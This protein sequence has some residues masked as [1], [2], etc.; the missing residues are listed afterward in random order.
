MN[1]RW[2]L[3]AC[4]ALAVC[5]NSAAAQKPGHVELSLVPRYSW[6][7]ADRDFDDAIGIGGGLAVYLSNRFKV[8]ADAAYH[9]TQ[10]ID[11]GADVTFV[12]LH[13]GFAYEQ[14]FSAKVRGVLGAHF[15]YIPKPEE[16]LDGTGGGLLAA[17]KVGLT[18]KLSFITQLTADALPPFMNPR[19]YVIQ[20]PITQT[21]K[22]VHRTDGYLALGAGLSLRLGK[23]AAAL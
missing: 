1:R 20:A 4:T 7:D 17:L 23:D 11:N 5:L 15:T 13:F 19:T 22:F 8:T 18:D 16:T 3:P 10:F 14:P 2:L 9:S 12:P 6:M 21:M